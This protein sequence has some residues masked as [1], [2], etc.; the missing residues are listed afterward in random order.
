MKTA[1]ELRKALDEALKPDSSG[2]TTPIQRLTPF[3]RD[4]VTYLEEHQ[5]PVVTMGADDIS[6]PLRPEN[7]F[8]NFE[9]VPEKVSSAP[10]TQAAPALPTSESGS[11]SKATA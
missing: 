3:L 4:L 5:F 9:L 1:S 7:N 6:K 8:A 10:A 2:K 11:A